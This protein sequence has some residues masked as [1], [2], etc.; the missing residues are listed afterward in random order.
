MHFTIFHHLFPKIAEKETRFVHVLKK[1]V[2]PL[3]SYGFF[4]SY[5]MDKTC[6]CRKSF[7]SVLQVNPDF[8]AFH[9]ATISYGWEDLSFYEEWTSF[10]N[11]ET[12]EEF[13]GPSLD[14]MQKQSRYAENFLDY[15]KTILMPDEEYM[16]RY[17]RHY[18][19]F[20]QKIGMRLPKEL[21]DLIDLNGPCPCQSGSSFRRCCGMKKKTTRRFKR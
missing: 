12:L 5:C 19:Y 10:M 1:G 9:A 4:H 7:I 2:L 15:F 14:L 17:P 8:E 13:K 16:S 21:R 6:D 11:E 18:A 20:K 3:G